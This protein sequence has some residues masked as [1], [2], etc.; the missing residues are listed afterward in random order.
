MNRSN[1]PYIVAAAL[2]VLAIGGW[3]I[4]LTGGNHEAPESADAGSADAGSTDAGAAGVQDAPHHADAS[5]GATTRD[6]GTTPAADAAVPTLG[7]PPS[8]PTEAS[9][10]G[11]SARDSGPTGPTGPTG[12][13]G[14]DAGPTTARAAAAKPPAATESKTN[15]A[16]LSKDAIQGV[17]SSMKPAFRACY[18]S[19]LGEFPEASGKVL[20]TFRVEAEDSSGRVSVI[21]VSEESTLMDD[22]MQNCLTD[23]FQDA[24]FP[25]PEDGAAVQVTYPFMFENR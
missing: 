11:Q 25:L 12:Q 24:E 16:S 4:F 5:H 8:L 21:E 13:S 7:T 6:A 14:P 23:A 17:I 19:L 3:V 22:K 18:N 9:D 20:V 1:V 2:I 15:K 10:A